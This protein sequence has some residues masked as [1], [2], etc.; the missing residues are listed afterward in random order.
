V[1][2]GQAFIPDQKTRLELG[3]ELHIAVACKA[4]PK[5]EKLLGQ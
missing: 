3:D 1:R 4:V 2:R 5:L